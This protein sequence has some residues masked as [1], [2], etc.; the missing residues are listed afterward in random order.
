LGTFQSEFE[1]FDRVHV[2]GELRAHHVSRGGTETGVRRKMF[3]GS[4]RA[5]RLAGRPVLEPAASPFTDTG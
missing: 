2:A 1:L 3:S 5:V 4:F